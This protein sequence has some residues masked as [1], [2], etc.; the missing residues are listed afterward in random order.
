MTESSQLCFVVPAV[1]KA[2]DRLIAAGPAFVMERLN[3]HDRRPLTTHIGFG[4]GP[5]SLPGG[6]KAFSA[7]RAALPTGQRSI[8][9]MPPGAT[10]GIMVLF[11][12]QAVDAVGTGNQRRAATP[13]IVAHRPD[14]LVTVD[15]AAGRVHCWRSPEAS[16]MSGHVIDLI[17]GKAEAPTPSLPRVEHR[18]AAN[19]S[20]EDYCAMAVRAQAQ[21]APHGDL[22]GIVLSV[23]LTSDG[24]TDP[25][26]A[27]WRLRAINPS[28]YM[29]LMRN[30]ELDAW[31]ATSLTLAEF[32]GGRILAET[33]GA[34]H[35][36][37]DDAFVWSPSEKEVDEYKVVID[38]LREDLKA[39]A[40]P[41]SL[42]LDA[43]KEERRFFKLAHLFASFSAIPRGNSMPS[44]SC[45]CYPR[46]AQPSA[47]PSRSPARSSTSSRPRRAAPFRARSPF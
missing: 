29:F 21:M 36:F 41:G 7:L 26:G 32:V 3:P 19:L 46:T 2:A 16:A 35:P 6:D 31:G 14:T 38:A 30:R 1:A 18:W 44:R 20:L 9:G 23:R 27:Y 34:T 28:P 12:Y 33:D 47:I 40:E 45:A 10:G 42:S 17:H 15:H 8:A 25:L 43:D 13:A 4:G 24:E 11:G 37:E 22:K 39:V 5:L